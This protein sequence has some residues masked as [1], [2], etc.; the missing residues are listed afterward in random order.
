M[1]T[2]ISNEIKA[3]AYLYASL[4]GKL[5]KADGEIENLGLLGTQRVTVTGVQELAEA[6]IGVASLA[7]FRWHDCGQGATAEASGDTAMQSL[8]GS[9]VGS[10]RSQGSQTSGG[11]TNIYRTVGTMSFI[12]TLAVT[13][14]GIFDLGSG[15]NLWDRTVFAAVNVVSGDRV[16]FTYDLSCVAG[17]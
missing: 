15:G 5:L 12:G 6:F 8:A 4:Y 17:G 1:L 3:A 14:H 13:E 16:E 10:L 9:T 11:A 2:I 7:A